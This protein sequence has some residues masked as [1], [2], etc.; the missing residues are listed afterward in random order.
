[1]KLIIYLVILG[2]ITTIE[3]VDVLK[4]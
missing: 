2:V 3:M 4:K 1:M